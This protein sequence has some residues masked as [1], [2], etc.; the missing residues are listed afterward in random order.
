PPE[1]TAEEKKAKEEYEKKVKEIQE[2]NAKIQQKTAIIEAALKDGNAAFQAKN[3]DAA[4]A[5]YDEGIAADPDFAGSAPVLMNNK[6]A[7]LRERAV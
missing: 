7:A 5:K 3:W 2:K 1:L 6:G 4:I